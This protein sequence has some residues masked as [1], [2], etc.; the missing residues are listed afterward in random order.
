MITTTITKKG[1]VTVP[2]SVRKALGIKPKD[3][4]AF[5]EKGSDFVI[6]KA[7]NF[8]SLR[9]SVKRK[10]SFDIKA[11]EKSAEEQAVR[12]YLKKK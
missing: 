3:K 11:M 12:D 9:G 10:N 5:I 2:V 1:Q 4:I 8:F 6:K 7:P